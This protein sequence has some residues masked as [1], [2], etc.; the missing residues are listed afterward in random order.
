MYRRPATGIIYIYKIYM[1]RYYAS[2]DGMVLDTLLSGASLLRNSLK[3][4]PFIG[5]HWTVELDR[6]APT[7]GNNETDL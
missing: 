4:L 5:K 6:K 3:E 1:P 7:T 2:T